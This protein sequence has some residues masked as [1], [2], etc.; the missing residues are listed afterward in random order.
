M[1]TEPANV[2]VIPVNLGKGM[3]L[4]VEATVLSGPARSERKD[5]S[6]VLSGPAR[7]RP[8]D[9]SFIPGELQFDIIATLLKQLQ[10]RNYG[11][12]LFALVKKYDDA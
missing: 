5:V 2:R 11:P 7:S 9:V 12:T 1:P 3:T 4:Q 10:V 8:K 6:S